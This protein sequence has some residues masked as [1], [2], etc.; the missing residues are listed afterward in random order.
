MA[1]ERF[2]LRYGGEGSK[3]DTD[4]ALVHGLPEAVV[5]DSTSRMLLVEA[6][7]EPLRRLVDTLP[8]WVMGPEQSYAVPDTRQRVERPPA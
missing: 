7:P 4:V 6:D 5:V 8:D 2:V 1:K 3:P